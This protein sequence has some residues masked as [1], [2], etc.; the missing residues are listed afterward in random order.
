MGDGGNIEGVCE[1]SVPLLLLLSSVT[2][3]TPAVLQHGLSE[4]P[5]LTHEVDKAYA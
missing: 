5:C 2:V 4:R 1:F 3:G